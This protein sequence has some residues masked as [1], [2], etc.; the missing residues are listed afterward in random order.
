MCFGH[1]LTLG[2]KSVVVR[3]ASF[4]SAVVIRACDCESWMDTEWPA[5]SSL[6]FLVVMGFQVRDQS[7]SECPELI[8]LIDDGMVVEISNFLVRI[9]HR[10]YSSLLYFVASSAWWIHARG[11]RLPCCTSLHSMSD[12]REPVSNCGKDSPLKMTAN[13]GPFLFLVARI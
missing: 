2:E 5:Y 3:L 6:S 11:A 1:D 12:T 13:L 7:Y 4:Y 9:S 10:S 8:V